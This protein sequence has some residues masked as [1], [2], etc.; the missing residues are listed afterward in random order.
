[1]LMGQLA[2]MFFYCGMQSDIVR[3]VKFYK[4]MKIC[5]PKDSDETK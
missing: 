4:V 1:M 5:F 2:K 3:Q